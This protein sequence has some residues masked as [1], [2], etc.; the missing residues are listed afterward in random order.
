M[1]IGLSNQICSFISCFCPPQKTEI[2]KVR[3]VKA[4]YIRRYWLCKLFT[5]KRLIKREAEIKYML[6]DFLSGEKK[7]YKNIVEAT[8]T[9]KPLLE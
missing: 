2:D 4:L 3:N 5:E 9:H 1:V 7:L 6:N 8:Q